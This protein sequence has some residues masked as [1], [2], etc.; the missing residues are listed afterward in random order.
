[1]TEQKNKKSML[2]KIF[3]KKAV[4][5]FSVLI[6][7]LALWYIFSQISFESVLQTLEGATWQQI[8]VYSIIQVVMFFLLSYRWKLVLNSQGINNVSLFRLNNYKLVGYGVSYITPSAKIGGEPVRAGLLSSREGIPFDKALSTVVI[9][10]TLELTTSVLFFVIG[11]IFMLMFF[12]IPKKLGIVVI[13]VSILL[14]IIFGIFNY[15]MIMGKS[16]FLKVFRLL[17]L[18]KIK[19]LKKFTKKLGDFEKLVIKFYHKDRK[20]LMYTFLV[21]LVAWALMFLEFGIAG[22]MVGQNLSALQIFLIFSFVGAA[23]LVPIPMALG[24]LEAGQISVFSLVDV[25]TATGVALSLLVRLK[26]I[27]ISA[28]GL[29][30]LTFYGLKFKE[31]VKNAKRLDKEIEVLKDLEKN[32]KQE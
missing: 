15:R 22:L 27:I 30:L 11:G 1:M 13:V 28:I 12:A 26:D 29:L 3:S 6:G 4:V 16:F 23:Y 24:A 19:K 8:L 17:G 14:V 25:K 10:K 21:S 32:S 18:S 20:F 2:S 5:V 9:D 31:V 7:I